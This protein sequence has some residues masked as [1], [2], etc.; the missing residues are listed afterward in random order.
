MNYKK[1]IEDAV[2]RTQELQLK[3]PPSPVP[4]SKNISEDKK[5][6]VLIHCLEMLQLHGFKSSQDLAGKCTDV[7]LMLQYFLKKDLNIDSYIT[8][9][10]RY[11]HDYIYCEM[12]DASIKSELNS[13]G[14]NEPIKAHVWLTLTDGTILDCTGE[15]HA[16]L[17][18]NRGNFPLHECIHLFAP[19]EKEDSIEGYYRPY[20]IGI[21]FLEKTGVCKILIPS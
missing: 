13:P 1:R 9:G 3:L 18:F 5:Q 17:I 16:D 11:W 6:E 12:S 19:N 2:L 8:I 21:D 4:F 10:D 20:L 7:H 15:A 14:L